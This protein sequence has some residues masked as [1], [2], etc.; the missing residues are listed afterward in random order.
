MAFHCNIHVAWRRLF[1]SG[2]KMASN[3]PRGRKAGT[4]RY[5][6]SFQ[7]IYNYRKGR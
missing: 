3:E 6:G 2:V 5:G 4:S 7:N 1:Q